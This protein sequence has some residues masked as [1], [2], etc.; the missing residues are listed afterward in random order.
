M[1]EITPEQYLAPEAL[2]DGAPLGTEGELAG[3]SINQ[4]AS[5]LGRRAQIEHDLEG[6]SDED[7]DS[8]AFNPK[9]AQGEDYLQ[10]LISKAARANSPAE[11]AKYNRLAEEVAQGLVTRQHV[12]K[13]DDLPEEGSTFEELSNAGHDV[14][15][16]LAQAA[17]D[18]NDETIAALNPL[19]MGNDKTLAKDTFTVIREYQQ[20]PEWFIHPDD[21]QAWDQSQIQE[22]A[23]Q[24]GDLTAKALEVTTLSLMN[25]QIT[26]VQMLQTLLKNPTVKRNVVTMLRN[27]QI[28]IPF[29]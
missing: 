29:A 27:G 7:I 25:K 11:R 24:Y 6:V 18:F 15:G 19:L 1:S 9:S 17:E 2:H 20:H 28:V 10:Q 5:G 3:K 14:K 23:S 12:R 8:G 21:I 16:V 4:M 26:P 13:P 22:I